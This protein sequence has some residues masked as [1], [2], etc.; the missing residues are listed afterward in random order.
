[1]LPT[2]GE[3]IAQGNSFTSRAGL[4]LVRAVCRRSN[5]RLRQL[6]TASVMALQSLSLRSS[7]ASRPSVL[8]VEDVAEVRLLLR[9]CFESDGYVVQ[10]ATDAAAARQ[11]LSE[12]SFD[13]VT[14]DLQMPG[15]NGLALARDLR[16]TS[17]VPL[18]MVTGRG[19][20]VDRVAGLEV[21]AD[22]YVTKP[23]HVR[24]VQA[25]A[26]SILRRTRPRASIDVARPAPTEPR[27]VL[28]FDRWVI[29]LDRRE[30][31]TRDGHARELTASEFELLS[32]FLKHPNRVLSRQRIMDLLKGADWSP[33]DRA[34]DTQV[35]RLRQKIEDDPSAPRLVKT[36]RGAG[37]LFA[38]TPRATSADN[39]Q[40][41]VDP[42]GF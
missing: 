31:A 40:A 32:V 29:D 11:A 13:L 15:E 5:A 17:D 8:V 22:D 33:F 9:R 14:L 4:F 20:L 24:E 12:Q 41:V 10:E 6:G 3:T 27:D 28:S 36:V 35:R 1:M 7:R 19:D 42:S 2:D 23:F 16:A 30:L 39:R 37:Y 26:R 25:R 34:I 38:E 21:G 18:M